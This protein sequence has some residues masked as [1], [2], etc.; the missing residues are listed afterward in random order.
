MTKAVFLS[1]AVIVLSTYIAGW[2]LIFIVAG[3]MDFIWLKL[4]QRLQSRV[5]KF[6]EDSEWRNAAAQFTGA[7]SGPIDESKWREWYLVLP[8]CKT[9]ERLERFL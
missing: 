8:N 9:K 5:N 3:L 2:V 4:W 1:R 7:N 6:S